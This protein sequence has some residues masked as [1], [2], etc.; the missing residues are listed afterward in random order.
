[1]EEQNKEKKPKKKKSLGF[2]IVIGSL[3]VIVFMTIILMISDST[4]QKGSLSYLDFMSDLDSG[5][6]DNVVYTRGDVFV[7]VIYKEGIAQE[8]IF[9]KK[10]GE[11]KELEIIDNQRVETVLNPSDD[12]FFKVISEKGVDVLITSD[13]ASSF[14]VALFGIIPTILLITCL[15]WVMKMQFGNGLTNKSGKMPIKS[16]T[17]FSD[18]AGMT[19]EKEELLFAIK[20]LQNQEDYIEKGVKPVKGILL[21]GPPGVGKT[22]LAKAVAGEAGVNFLSFSGSDFVEMFVGLGARRVRSMFDEAEKIKPCVV[23]IDEIDALGRKRIAGGNGGTQ[24]A[25]QTLVALLERMDG[26]NT[27]SGVLFIAATNRVD[28]LDSALLRPGR[29]DKT[30]HVSPPKT[31]EDREAIVKVHSQDKK[32]EEGVTCE[33]IA[34]QCY[35][36]TGAEI[37]AALN[38]AVLESFKTDRKGVIGLEDIDKAIMKLFAKGLAKGRHN[39]KDLYRVAVH[40][41]GHALMNKALGRN[42]VKVSIQPYSSGV[43]GVT[44]IDGESSGLDGLR[45]KS[46][47]INDIKVLYAGKVAEEVILGECSIG[48]SNDL[49]RATFIIRDF[50]GAYG[51]QEDSL[52]S[53]VG[54]SRE[55]MMISAN[56]ELLIKMEKVAKKVYTD[57][58]KYFENSEVKEILQKI[59]QNLSEN[60]V[61][62]DFDKEYEKYYLLKKSDKNA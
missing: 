1:M 2:K 5:Y 28:A 34:K 49:E 9:D 42:V 44:Q 48:A 30:I 19:E 36:L 54:L 60:E 20:S 8:E 43:G 51:M 45:T 55:N 29:F 18:V 53:L 39:S 26:M 10:T 12:D 6:I 40:E 32:F 57:V 7:K 41:T 38:D 17:K 35:G 50:I 22:L 3:F 58:I 37:A 33:K 52:L 11:I 15:V 24:E 31:K 23:F 46:D 16:T 25:D 56:E 14:L 13:S 62:Y 4:P 21:E 61:I 27:T 59:A 47:I